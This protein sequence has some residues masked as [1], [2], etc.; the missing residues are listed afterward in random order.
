MWNKID[1]SNIAKQ[2]SNLSQDDKKRVKQSLTK[3][4]N[5]ILITY[6]K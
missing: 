2:W 5:N 1:Y 6:L 3:D 4:E